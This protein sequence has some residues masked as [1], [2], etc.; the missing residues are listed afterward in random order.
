M[1]W[2]IVGSMA[3]WLIGSVLPS[4]LMWIGVPTVMK[5]SEAFFSAIRANSLSMIIGRAAVERGRPQAARRWGQSRS[6]S[7][8]L[9][10]ARVWASTFLTITAQ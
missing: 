8:M 3:C 5:M 9:V 2:I 1:R 7:L 4:I 6:S 10:L